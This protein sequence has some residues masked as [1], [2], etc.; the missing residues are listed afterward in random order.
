MFWLYVI[1][2]EPTAKIAWTISVD[3]LLSNI[4][5]QIPSHTIALACII[6]ACNLNGINGIFPIE[7][8]IYHSTRYKANAALCIICEL[9]M[10]N[11][12]ERMELTNSPNWLEYRDQFSGLYNICSEEM[13]RFVRKHRNIKQNMLHH[14]AVS[15]RDKELSR[16]GAVR[17]VLEW[18]RDRDSGE[19]TTHVD[20]TLQNRHNLV[21]DSEEL[22]N[23]FL[24]DPKLFDSRNG[25]KK[26]RIS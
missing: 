5:L 11:F 18:E 13:D 3:A 24:N 1:V 9:Y 4:Y 8:A 21:V 6:L 16:K 10:S 25:N 20:M 7:S 17:Y 22:E 2:D 14:R 23:V 19:L 26:A 12:S 15:Q